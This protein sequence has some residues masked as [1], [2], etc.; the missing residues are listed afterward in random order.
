MII[1]CYQEGGTLKFYYKK[2]LHTRDT[3]IVPQEHLIDLLGALSTT[4]DLRKHPR[5][6]WLKEEAVAETVLMYE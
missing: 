5:K 6:N 2:N 1:T 4:I 3:S